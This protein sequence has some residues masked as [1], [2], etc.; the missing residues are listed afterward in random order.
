M[1]ADDLTGACDCAVAFTGAGQVIRIYLDDAPEA[2]S[3]VFAVSTESRDL[4]PWEQAARLHRFAKRMPH[5]AEIFKKVDSV[6]RG[7]TFAEIAASM[8]AF[9]ARLTVLAPAHPVHGRRVR[10]GMLHV[11]GADWH[12]PLDLMAGL[13]AAGC[14][15]LLV[16]AENASSGLRTAPRGALLLCDAWTSGDLETIVRSVAE[17]GERVL[18]IGSGGLAHALAGNRQNA[19]RCRNESWPTGRVVF[20]VGSAHTITREQIYYLQ[21]AA[22]VA[23]VGCD[24]AA[25]RSSFVLKAPRGTSEEVVRAMLMALDLSETACLFLTGGDT[26]M[27]VCRALGIRSL[28]VM[29]EFAP[30]V[31]VCVAEGGPFAGMRIVT[32]SGGFG[33]RDLLYR[34]FEAFSQP[35]IRASRKRDL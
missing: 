28:R 14:E 5:G 35:A 25:P 16:D 3:G 29:W 10:N 26:A 8:A 7:N 12:E 33:A 22:A 21:Q 32:K 31:P 17:R 15:P 13:R 11:E 30:G 1:I 34:I 6:F 24:E 9:P 2:L 18:W 20:V 19:A 4:E 27:L 23:M